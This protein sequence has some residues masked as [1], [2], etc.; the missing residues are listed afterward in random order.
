[1]RHATNV[2]FRTNLPVKRDVR[3]NRNST[4]LV[5]KVFFTHL[6]TGEFHYTITTV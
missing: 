5:N 2:T 1:M 6:R 4:V 3:I